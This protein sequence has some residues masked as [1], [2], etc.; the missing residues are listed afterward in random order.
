[1]A[2]QEVRT[3]QTGAV[4]RPNLRRWNDVAN[5]TVQLSEEDRIELV[6][7]VLR[8]TRGFDPR[9]VAIALLDVMSCNP[10]LAAEV[11]LESRQRREQLETL[12]HHT[13]GAV[14]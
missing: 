14:N 12:M 1:M 3:H 6:K 7:E 4:R 10:A 8:V 9:L 13:R 11:T 5:P 2:L